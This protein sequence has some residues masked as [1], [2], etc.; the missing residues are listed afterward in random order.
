[1]GRCRR[2]ARPL[3]PRLARSAGRG[4][5]CRRGGQSEG[6]PTDRRRSAGHGPLGLSTPSHP[7]RLPDD[8]LQL[9]S[10]L[11]LTALLCWGSRVGPVRRCVRLE[12]LGSA[13][14]GGDREL[15]GSPQR[16]RSVRPAAPGPC[17]G[18]RRRSPGGQEIPGPAGRAERPR[19]EPVR[20]VPPREPGTRMGDGCR[21]H[22]RNRRA[23]SSAGRGPH[24]GD[25]RGT[26]VRPR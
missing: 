7:R 24:R 1:M 25:R 3:L 14:A 11:A 13:Y 15:P 16:S 18:E 22:L 20:G 2:P 9:A 10:A 21:P 12:A 4:P 6:R 8:V 26:R 19:G 17:P 5:P 23:L